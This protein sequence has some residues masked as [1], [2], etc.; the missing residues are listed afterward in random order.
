MSYSSPLRH[1]APRDTIHLEKVADKR[2]ADKKMLFY[3]SPNQ[4]TK[5]KCSTG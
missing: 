1:T 5:K 3:V 4:L 2:N